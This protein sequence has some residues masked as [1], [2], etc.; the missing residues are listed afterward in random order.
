MEGSFSNR[1]VSRMLPDVSSVMIQQELS[2]M[3]DEGLITRSGTTKGT[4][5]VNNNSKQ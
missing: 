5:Y 3:F 4:Q 1:D 2:K